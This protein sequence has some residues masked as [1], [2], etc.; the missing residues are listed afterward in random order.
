MKKT[1]NIISTILKDLGLNHSER[2]DIPNREVYVLSSID[3]DGNCIPT[4]LPCLYEITKDGARRIEEKESFEI[5]EKNGR[6]KFCKYYKG[7]EQCPYEYGTPELSFW[8]FEKDYWETFDD[9]LY[10]YRFD[11]RYFEE[12]AR[13]YIKENKDKKNFMTSD[14]PI[15]QKGFVMFA[16]EMLEKWVPY[17]VDMIFKY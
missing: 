3:D 17:K 11:H 15:E 13:T 10:T 14:A 9:G 4:G 12:R 5:L 7:E 6:Y 16:E 2:I 8:Y 1:P